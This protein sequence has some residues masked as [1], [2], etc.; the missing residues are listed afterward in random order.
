RNH[1]KKTA[2]IRFTVLFLSVFVATALA[3][4]P[5]SAYEKMQST[6]PEV[7]KIHVLR[8]DVQPTEKKDTSEV[9]M[10]AEVVK[11][12]RSK[13][14]IKPSDMITVKY[15]VIARQAGWVGPGEVPILKDNA[16][17]VAYLAPAGEELEYAPAAGAMSFDRF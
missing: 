11:V 14:K 17:T 12:G 1:R 4:L 8:V 16:E 6:A 2:M 9:T 3:E 5:P 10:L 7:L 15:N 13:T